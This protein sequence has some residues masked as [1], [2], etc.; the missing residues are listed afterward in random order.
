MGRKNIFEV[1]KMAD[2]V[3]VAAKEQKEAED[4]LEV[5]AGGSTL[6]EDVLEASITG[7]RLS[8]KATFASLLSWLGGGA[9]DRV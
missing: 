9:G 8:L 6:A 5:D 3:E 4:L 1:F 2:E 7:Q